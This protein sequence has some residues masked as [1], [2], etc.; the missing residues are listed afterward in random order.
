MVTHSSSATTY[1]IQPALTVVPIAAHIGD[2][3]L[4]APYP[5]QPNDLRQNLDER[6]RGR[7]DT[8]GK[9]ELSLAH[10]PQS[11]SGG[12][13]ADTDFSMRGG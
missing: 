1:A 11:T 10:R 6:H 4:G 12:Q 13:R 2:T 8:Y 3:P 5:Q 9:G 7:H